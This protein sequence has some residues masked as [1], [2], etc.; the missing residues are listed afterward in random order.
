MNDKSPVCTRKEHTGDLEHD[1]YS[2]I[3]FFS[4]FP[5]GQMTFGV[6]TT[7]LNRIYHGELGMS[8]QHETGEKHVLET[9]K[10]VLDSRILRTNI[11]HRK[12]EKPRKIR[13]ISL[14]VLYCIQFKKI[15]FFPGMRWIIYNFRLALQRGICDN[16]MRK[17]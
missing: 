9:K 7:E 6:S 14:P 17:H 11:R 5:S 1:R 13:G 15:R 16:M 10:A 2:R 4:S 3:R 12:T 8:I